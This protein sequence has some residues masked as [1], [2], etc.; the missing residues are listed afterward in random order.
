VEVVI[1]E[2]RR[3]GGCLCRQWLSFTTGWDE[4]VARPLPI[5]ST[6][7]FLKKS[8]HVPQQTGMA[9]LSQAPINA[10]VIFINSV[11]WFYMWNKRVPVETVSFEFNRVT[12][13]GE[14]WRL[15]TST[16]SHLDIMHLVFNMMSMIPIAD[17][18]FMVRR[19]HINTIVDS[20]H[21]FSRT[22]F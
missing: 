13:Q 11:L 2:R 3:S 20:F 19:S 12:Q 4:L 14:W 22:A 5:R 8:D 6:I 15:L 17:L 21:L 7:F 1:A 18:E 10:L 16:F 9:S